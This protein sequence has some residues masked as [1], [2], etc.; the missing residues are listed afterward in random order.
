[1]ARASSGE[2]ASHPIAWLAIALGAIAT[3]LALIV[4]TILRFLTPGNDPP[5]EAKAAKKK[6]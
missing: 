4:L 2:L 6:A 1:M 5:P 3:V